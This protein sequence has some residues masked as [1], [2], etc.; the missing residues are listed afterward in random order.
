MNPEITDIEIRGETIDLDQLLKLA[1]IAGTGGHA[2]FIIQEGMVQVNG[3]S[4]SRRRR[5]L[6][7]HDVVE[8][9]G[10]GAFRVVTIDQQPRDESQ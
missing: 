8:V 6:R 9:E 7:D 10:E 5:T 4:E 3:E 1:G 2:K